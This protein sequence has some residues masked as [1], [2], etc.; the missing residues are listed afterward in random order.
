MSI[1][2]VILRKVLTIVKN[3]C[4]L[5]LG[6]IAWLVYRAYLQALILEQKIDKLEKGKK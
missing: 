4:I 6:I 5:P 1:V 2:K 3:I